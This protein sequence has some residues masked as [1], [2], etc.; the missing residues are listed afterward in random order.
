MFNEARISN[1]YSEIF[2]LPKQVNRYY[3]ELSGLKYLFSRIGYV[4][5]LF[6]HNLNYDGAFSPHS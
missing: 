3:R 4:T 5:L 2:D 1:D 6:S